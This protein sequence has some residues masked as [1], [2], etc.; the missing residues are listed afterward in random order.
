MQREEKKGGK[1]KKASETKEREGNLQI[2]V[3]LWC[4]YYTEGAIKINQLF[5]YNVWQPKA[6]EKTDLRRG[7]KRKSG[8]QEDRLKPMKLEAF[9]SF[10]LNLS[11]A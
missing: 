11:H 2:S 10:Q 1:E 8:E 5:Y 4:F 9:V 7:G 6:Q 3:T